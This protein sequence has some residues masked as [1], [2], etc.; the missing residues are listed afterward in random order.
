MVYGEVPP[1]VVEEM[2]TGELT[3]GLVGRIVKLVDKG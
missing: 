3:D 2:V 1:A